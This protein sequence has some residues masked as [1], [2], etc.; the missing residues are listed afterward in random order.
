MKV[1]LHVFV[2]A[3]ITGCAANVQRPP[4]GAFAEVCVADQVVNS[5]WG[6]M[7]A[8]LYVGQ[9][10][11][12]IGVQD[13]DGERWYLVSFNTNN[14]SAAFFSAKTGKFR[15]DLYINGG[16]RVLP[17]MRPNRARLSL[18]GCN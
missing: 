5:P 17:K 12:V 11:N 4:I 10:L 6:M 9:R 7:V 14:D 15:E 1:L 16:E 8:N 18:N 13:K 3:A 2:A